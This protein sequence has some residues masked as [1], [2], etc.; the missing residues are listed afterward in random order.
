MLYLEAAASMH[1]DAMADTAAIF[2]VEPAINVEVYR[3]YIS[4]PA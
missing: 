2:Q 3:H 1:A 4:S